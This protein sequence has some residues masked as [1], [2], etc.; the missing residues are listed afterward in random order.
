MRDLIVTGVQTCALP[1]SVRRR[2]CGDRGGSRPPPPRAGARLPPRSPHGLRRTDLADAHVGAD[3]PRAPVLVGDLRL[4]LRAVAVAVEGLDEGRVLLADVA[5]AHLT[6]PRDL[7]V[8]GVELLVQDQELPDLGPLEHLVL[9][10]AAI[11]ALDLLLDQLVDFRLLAEVGIA[12]IGNPAALR[13]VPDRGEI[14]VHERG[15]V[16]AVLADAHG[17]LHVRREL[18]LVLDVLGG[19]DRAAGQPGHVLR[20]VD[21]LEVAGRI[22]EPGV[23]RAH[24]AALQ[25]HLPR[26]FLVLEVALEDAGALVEHLALGR[27]LQLDALDRR[28]DGVQAHLAIALDRDEHARLGHAVELLDVDA[29]AAEEDEDLGA[30][31]LAGRVGAAHAPQA[32]VVAQRAVD[33]QPAERIERAAPA[34]RALARE[35]RPFQVLR[36]REEEAHDLALG[37]RAVLDAHHHVGE[38]ALPDARRREEVGRADLAQV[39]QHGG[40]ALRT[41]DREAHQNCLRVR[42]DVIADPRHRQVRENFFVR[43]QILRA[44]RV[45]GGDDE[46]AMREHRALRHARRPRGVADDRDVLAAAPGDLVVEVR[47]MAD[48]E[49]APGLLQ[50]GEAQEARFAVGA[51]AAWIVVHDRLESRAARTQGEELVHLL[52]V[53]DDGEARL[54]VV[55]DV[56]HLFLD[57]V[58]VER[59][60]HAAERLRGEHRPVE[61]GAVVADDG[62][63]VAAP[64]AQRGEAQGDRARLGE[65]VPPRGGLPDAVVLLADGHAVRHPLRVDAGELRK[66]VLLARRYVR[67]QIPS[68]PRFTRISHR[69]PT[70]LEGAKWRKCSQ[71][72]RGCQANRDMITNIYDPR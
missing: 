68:P 9:Q 49:L 27:D 59:H 33:E 4:D 66:R 21:D 19:E 51:E 69:T 50:L 24:P 7:L 63:L 34:R 53:L 31:R 35:P 47:G 39:V 5:A 25:H 14:D 22:E 70:A 61:L 2:P 30:D 64:E 60:R 6:R 28:A 65:V 20:A 1:I 3:G 46:I 23:P 13:P 45:E 36:Q 43:L 40:R 42:E 8:V 67:L 10:Q 72:A 29:E 16:R 52:L 18:Q 17:L 32:E 57:G 54:R 15:D 37:P 26:G 58:L 44:R 12:R 56:L 11:D 48:L 62:D 55:D 71:A 38:Q 41:V